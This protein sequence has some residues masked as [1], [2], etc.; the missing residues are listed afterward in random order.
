MTS[1]NVI[2][3]ELNWVKARHEC[4]LVQ[5]FKTLELGVKSDIDAINALILPGVMLKFHLASHGSRF[6]ATCEVN[7]QHSHSVD[8]GLKDNEIS[9]SEDNTPKFAATLALTNTGACK[10][11]V[12]NEELEQ[13]QVR[14]KALETFFF[15]QNRGRYL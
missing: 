14:R 5:I 15:D 8:F 10:L 4:S 13:W 7:G 2:P 12:G 3:E 9:I 11:R 1:E 6:S